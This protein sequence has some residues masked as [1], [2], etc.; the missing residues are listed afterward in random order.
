MLALLGHTPG[1]GKHVSV[2]RHMYILCMISGQF[3]L[4]H[5]SSW[6]I[7]GVRVHFGGIMLEVMRETTETDSVLHPHNS[8]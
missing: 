4:V 3:D 1:I 2:V 5:R 8:C 6:V 7:G